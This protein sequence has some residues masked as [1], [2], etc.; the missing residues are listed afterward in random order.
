M[1]PIKS[2]IYIYPENIDKWKKI[3]HKTEVINELL[4]ESFESAHFPDITYRGKPIGKC[5][6][7]INLTKS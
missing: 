1:K 4:S 6:R 5:V 2:T 3:K 7:T